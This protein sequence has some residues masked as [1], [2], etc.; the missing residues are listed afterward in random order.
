MIFGPKQVPKKGRY[1]EDSNKCY[2]G[3][4][5]C[6]RAQ[7]QQNCGSEGQ[8]GCWGW[9]SALNSLKP[10]AGTGSS[11]EPKIE[12]CAQ[13]EG[14]SLHWPGRE[15]R[16]RTSHKRAWEA[17]SDETCPALQRC[18][19]SCEKGLLDLAQGCWQPLEHKQWSEW[20]GKAATGEK[21]TAR[22]SKTGCWPAVRRT[23]ASSVLDLVLPCLHR[24]EGPGH[25]STTERRPK[26]L[27]LPR[28]GEG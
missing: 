16:G 4:K 17:G 9:R 8:K 25:L 1:A 27:L 21:E 5:I 23:L 14:R 24:T 11:R 3:Y 20:R 28:K 13:G 26:W 15:Q 22:D 6:L 19:K 12:L 2:L 10:R 7:R 18:R